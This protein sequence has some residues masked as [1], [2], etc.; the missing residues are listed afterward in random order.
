MF[1]IGTIKNGKLP[2]GIHLNK[3]SVQAL[4]SSI[5]LPEKVRWNEESAELY[6][7]NSQ[8]TICFKKGLPFANMIKKPSGEFFT[9]PEILQP[10]ISILT[11]S[12]EKTGLDIDIAEFLIDYLSDQEAETPEVR[13]MYH[14]MK[15]L[16]T[17]NEV[18]AEKAV[19]YFLGRGR[20]LTPSG[21]DH[22]VGLLAIHK[23]SNAF[24]PVF[25]NTLKKILNHESVTTDIAK[26]Y[27]LYALNGQFS[28][29][30][31]QIINHLS[32]DEWNIR[33]VEKYLRE[34]ITV[35]HSSGIDT[36]FGL[37]IGILS[38]KYWRNN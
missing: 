16:H 31:V 17:N 38:I 28:S 22:L 12:V 2:F 32:A 8:V 20:G 7:E 21:D 19:R 33:I 11:S 35:G 23:V 29:S 18:D 1:F 6:F 30:I 25:V 26:E 15:T 34:L 14:L 37:L 4:L 36:A 10:F 27:L 3:E 24:S 9:S 5:H 13:A